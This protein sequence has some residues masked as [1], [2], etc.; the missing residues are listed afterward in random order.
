MSHDSLIFDDDDLAVDL[1]AFFSGLP[2]RELS[3]QTRNLV[4]FTP[5]MFDMLDELKV[6]AAHDVTLL[7]VGETGCGKTY[8]ARLLCYTS[9]R[10]ATTSAAS[11][12]PAVHCRRI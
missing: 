3:G 2:R 8:L 7:F 11:R 9:C 12:W 4:T 6:A 1:P 10:L 5:S